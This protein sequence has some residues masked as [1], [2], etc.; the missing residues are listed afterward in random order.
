MRVGSSSK[1][2]AWSTRTRPASKSRRPSSG[3]RTAPKSPR[4]SETAMACI[5]KSRRGRSSSMEFV[6]VTVGSA[7]GLAYVSRRVLA[8]STSTSP[9]T[10]LAVPN[11]EPF[12]ATPPR[13]PAREPTGSS[14]CPEAARSSSAGV[15]RSSRSL[16]EPPTR[17]TLT[18]ERAA[19]SGT[20][21]RNARCS[22]LR[23]R[24]KI[25]D[26]LLRL[27][28]RTGHREGSLSQPCSML[29][30]ASAPRNRPTSPASSS[31]AG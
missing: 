12:I 2:R 18:P 20:R 4:F 13:A 1:L 21:N 17:W 31:R 27:P 28:F 5:V 29:N 9:T 19:A 26:K 14:S 24:S 25:V 7:P 22:L 3:S 6:K 8:T 16:T 10:T 15:R 30:P 23:C 11:W